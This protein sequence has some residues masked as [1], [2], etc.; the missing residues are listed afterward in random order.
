[1]CERESK[2]VAVWQQYATGASD[3]DLQSLSSAQI[4]IIILTSASAKNRCTTE[5]RDQPDTAANYINE[6]ERDQSE[7]CGEEEGLFA[8]ARGVENARGM[9]MRGA[10]SARGEHSR[11][12]RKQMPE[13]STRSEDGGGR[14]ARG[15]PWNFRH[16]FPRNRCAAG[17]FRAE[18]WRVSH[19]KWPDDHEGGHAMQF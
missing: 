3:V 9:A 14:R 7:A 18:L 10:V 1:M 13:P 2:Q 12:M 17:K 15:R 8:Q 4:T 16:E 6:R 11:R 5:G 19:A